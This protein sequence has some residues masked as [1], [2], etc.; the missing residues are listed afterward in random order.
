MITI[1]IIVHIWITILFIISLLN[2]KYLNNQDI[3]L[4]IIH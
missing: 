2:L 1:Y 4:E 3:F